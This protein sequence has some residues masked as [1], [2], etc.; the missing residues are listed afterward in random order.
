[1]Q[2]AMGATSTSPTQGDPRR[3]EAACQQRARSRFGNAEDPEAVKGCEVTI[4]ETET[5]L[6]FHSLANDG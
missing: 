2:H 6:Q 1:M 5:E 4:A 3:E